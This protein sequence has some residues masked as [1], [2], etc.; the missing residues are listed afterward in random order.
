VPIPGTLWVPPDTERNYF[1]SHGSFG[2][3]GVQSKRECRAR[4]DCGEELT[5]F[6]PYLSFFIHF[7]LT[8]NTVYFYLP[9]KR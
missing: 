4:G 1:R 6:L 2:R 3:Q 9:S 8:V 5:L 7:V